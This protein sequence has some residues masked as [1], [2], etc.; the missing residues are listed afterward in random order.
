[1]R[2]QDRTMRVARGTREAIIFGSASSPCP[3]SCPHRHG[4]PHFDLWSSFQVNRLATTLL[5]APPR[6]LSQLQPES[7]LTNSRIRPAGYL[8]RDV[9]L[10]ILPQLTLESV[11]LQPT[12]RP[13]RHVRRPEQSHA[14]QKRPPTASALMPRELR[15]FCDWS[16]QGFRPGSARQK[17]RRQ[18][19]RE[20]RLGNREGE[21]A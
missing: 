14:R 11:R 2:A 8:P 9:S 18:G 13:A 3:V 12:R 10:H 6:R 19:R 7:R 4:S 16:G 1:M 15:H 21:R 5:P 20:N 17:V